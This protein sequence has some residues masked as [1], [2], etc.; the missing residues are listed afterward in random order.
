MYLK[1]S[2]VTGYCFRY[3]KQS[4]K[5]ISF[6]LERGQCLVI[7][8]RIGTGK[9]TLLPTLLGLL[10]KD[11]G[12]IL[13]NGAPISDGQVAAAGTLAELLSVNEKSRSLWGGT[14]T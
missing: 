6:R 8:E 9:T 14:A 2:W 13:W 3:W 11:Q 12:Q 10:P 4:I 7:T 1:F 5:R